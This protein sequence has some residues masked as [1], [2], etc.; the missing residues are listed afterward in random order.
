VVGSAISGV[1]Y[2]ELEKA[3]CSV[4][5]FNGRPQEFLDYILAEEEINDLKATGPG[6]VSVPEPEE[7]S[8]GC[9]QISIKDIQQNRHGL[10]SKQVLLSFLRKGVFYSLEVLC[11]HIPP[12]LHTE[13]LSGGIK[14][15]IERI[16]CNEVKV[17]INKKCCC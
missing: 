15:K 3:G 10:T 13:I 6:G 1:P 9:Y 16:S 4:W 12:W 7:V 8:E 11:S 14:G 5:K 2:F 17:L